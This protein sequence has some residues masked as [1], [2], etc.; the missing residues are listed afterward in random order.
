MTPEAN[1]E[2]T[3]GKKEP[4]PPLDPPPGGLEC[5]DC[6]C[7]DPLVDHT[8]RVA[9]AIVRYRRCRH[10]GRRMTTWERPNG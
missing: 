1:P 8:K 7:Q 10:C 6:G 2:A 5:P 9:H 3:P 4:W